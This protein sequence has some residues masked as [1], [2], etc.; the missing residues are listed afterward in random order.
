MMPAASKSAAR[1]FPLRSVAS[2]IVAFG[3]IGA[4]LATSGVMDTE[5]VFGAVWTPRAPDFGLI[6]QQ[7]LVLKTHL[8]AAIGAF[9]IGCVIMLR[10]K[11]RGLHKVLG[12]SWVVAMAVTAV[13]SFFLTSL[14]GDALSFIHLISGWTII[15]LPMAVVA[16]RRRD[17]TA[18]RKRMTGLFTGGLVIAGALTFLPGRLMWHVFFG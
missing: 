11:G 14:N 12:W 2:T 13:S 3:L 4:A 1:P 9:A 15:M 17:V 18:H 16:I 5:R 10:P 8:F 7:S 6:A